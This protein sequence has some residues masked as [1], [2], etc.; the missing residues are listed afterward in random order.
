MTKTI[1]AIEAVVLCVVIFSVLYVF[2]YFHPN[3]H[4]TAIG[5]IPMWLA[6]CFFFS[7]VALAIIAELI[8]KVEKGR[9]KFVKY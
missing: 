1:I 9:N 8:Q 6:I 5:I 4:E 2:S 3:F 7:G